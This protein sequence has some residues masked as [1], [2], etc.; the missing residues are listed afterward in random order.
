[1]KDSRPPVDW[2]RI[3][4]IRNENRPAVGLG[5]AAFVLLL[6]TVLGVVLFTFFQVLDPGP[7]SDFIPFS[8]STS[9]FTL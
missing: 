2:K 9:I 8:H 4:Q 5:L 6:G 3:R 7:V 1:M